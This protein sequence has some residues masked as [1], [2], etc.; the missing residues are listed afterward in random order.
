M[1]GF[2]RRP[3]SRMY[4][5][6]LDLGE[7]YYSPMTSYLDTDRNT[8]GETPG[9]L[10]FSERLAKK[11]VSGR[12]YE[13]TDLRERYSRSSSLTREASAAHA[14]EARAARAASEMRTASTYGSQAADSTSAWA[15]RNQLRQQALRA[16]QTDLHAA[17]TSIQAQREET[18]QEMSKSSAS[19]ATAYKAA[20]MQQEQREKLL[21]INQQSSTSKLQSHR[22]E[23]QMQKYVATQQVDDVSKKIADIR[24][25]PYMENQE[26]REAEA[27][28]LRAR[29]R[30]MD[31][32]RELEDITKKAIMTSTKAV[33]SAKQ[34][35]YEASME[36]E[37]E[38][39]ASSTKKSR[40]VIVESSSKIRA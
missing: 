34:M 7:H 39:K 15:N 26:I 13:A 35:A 17:S 32:E 28:S 27:A 9:A 12:R 19:S 16:S 4:S 36:A 25:Q 20:R 1:P 11:W 23:E 33:K 8:R 40:K 18:T 3:V 38:A 5:Y 6:N 10:T 14:E 24:M 31:L 29:A 30:I 21:Q 22:R 37:E 2:W